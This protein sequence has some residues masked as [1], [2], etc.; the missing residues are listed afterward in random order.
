[1]QM[2]FLA[3]TGVKAAGERE[4]SGGSNGTNGCAAEQPGDQQ[5]GQQKRMSRF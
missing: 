4:A 5:A 2:R 3:A 1:M